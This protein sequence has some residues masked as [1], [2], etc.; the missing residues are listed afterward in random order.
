MG[1][2]FPLVLWVFCVSLVCAS[3]VLSFRWLSGE[4]LLPTGS[5]PSRVSA[6]ASSAAC[7]SPVQS[8]GH[9]DPALPRFNQQFLASLHN[10]PH[11]GSQSP[12]VW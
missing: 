3:L 4:K 8:N 11:L 10:P 12:D 2:F 7:S 5:P 6:S 9:M 1:A